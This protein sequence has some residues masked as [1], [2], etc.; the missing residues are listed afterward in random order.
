MKNIPW[1][2]KYRPNNFNDI[3]LD[4]YN[5][6]ILENIVSKSYF[7]NLLFYGPPGTGKTTTII[8]LI[9][10][11]QEK[12]EENYKELIIH[13]N[14]SDERGIETIRN[15]IHSF[16]NSKNLFGKGKKFVILDEID[17]MTTNAQEALKSLM[18]NTTTDV[19]FCLICNYISKIDVAL[20]NVLLK[21]RFNQ[22]PKE[23][24]ITFLNNIVVKESLQIKDENIEMIQKT[25]NSDLR[26]MINYLQLNHNTLKLKN[27]TKI[28]NSEIY[29]TLKHKKNIYSFIENYAKVNELEIKDFIKQ[30]F[31]YIL[32]KKIKEIENID[33]LF[34]NTSF[35]VHNLNI[36]E[37][38]LLHYTSNI[39][40][41][42]NYK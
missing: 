33:F 1:V 9:K 16:V 40:K 39:L 27:N 41:N 18:N 19:C 7:P 30:I 6:I 20:Q 11:Y 10:K 4:K 15:Q 8:S 3:V 24:I 34:K 17:H 23:Q 42:I 21:L 26:S 22:L 13:L 12:Y 35:I 25:Y 14:A 38:Y 37:N 28:T 32:E 2:E 5:K 29:E 31:S 36:N